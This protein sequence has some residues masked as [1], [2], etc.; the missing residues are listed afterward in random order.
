MS[1]ALRPDGLLVR[2]GGDRNGSP[3]ER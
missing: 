3:Q 2:G 1:I